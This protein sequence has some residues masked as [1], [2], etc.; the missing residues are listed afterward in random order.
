MVQLGKYY[1][2]HAIT[3]LL[4]SVRHYCRL[5]DE[6]E[7]WGW[8]EHDGSNY[9]RQT[10]VDLKHNLKM[11]IDVRIYNGGTSWLWLICQIQDLCRQLD[12]SNT[13]EAP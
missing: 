3:I 10:I 7:V 4:V 9:G 6:V 5:E 12:G 11:V 2:G 1:I 13:A 8:E